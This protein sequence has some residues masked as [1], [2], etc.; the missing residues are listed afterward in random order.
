MIPMDADLKPAQPVRVVFRWLDGL[1]VPKRCFL[2]A[3]TALLAAC[4]PKPLI[5]RQM[6]GLVD[7]GM[8]AFERDDDL[9]LMEK[10][11]PANVKLLEAMLASSP[12][13]CRL[14][15]L[16]SRLYGSYAF[17]FMETRLE[18]SFFGARTSDTQAMDMASLKN[19]VNRYYEKGAGYALTA[20]EKYAPGATEA[21]RKVDT[22]RPYL[23]SL[24][25][26]AVAPLFWYGFNLGGWVNRNLD[27]IR[28]V[29]RAHVVRT[30]MER[31]I[32]LD[33]GYHHGGAH[34]F[35]MVYFG[36]RPPMMGGNQAVARGHYRQLKR[37][38]G[39]DY[40]MVDLFYARYCLHQQQ[41]REAFVDVMQRIIAHPQADNDR[42]LYNAIAGRRA[43]IYL[44]AVDTLFEPR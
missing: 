7:S 36:S 42:A 44:S 12:D 32:G 9:D 31:V 14:L 40:L 39:N 15:T 34:L 37:I 24:D 17:G 13:D 16:L 22:L 27:S 38:T 29:S 26:K 43:A 10:A 35:L 23:D 6:T 19:Q 41:D 4:S 18:A 25:K 8:V 20:L 33:P 3:V 5:V 30:I 11:I 1:M 2:L 21:F 28:A